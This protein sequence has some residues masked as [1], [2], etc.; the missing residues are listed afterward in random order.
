MPSRLSDSPL[1]CRKWSGLLRGGAAAFDVFANSS[2]VECASP[3]QFG[4]SH[5]QMHRGTPC[6]RLGRGSLANHT[7]AG[8]AQSKPAMS[9]HLCEGLTTNLS[10]PMVLQYDWGIR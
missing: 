2:S 7:A 1:Q 9:L 6:A 8:A 3:I 10:R 5:P 4:R